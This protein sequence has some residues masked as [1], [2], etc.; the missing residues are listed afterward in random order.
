MK[1]NLWKNILRPRS[2][3]KKKNA[4]I[5]LRLQ[6]LTRLSLST[7][8]AALCPNYCKRVVG[9]CPTTH[10]YSLCWHIW[11]PPTMP[12][13]RGQAEHGTHMVVAVLYI[14]PNYTRLFSHSIAP[15]EVTYIVTLI[16]HP[17]S[18]SK[19]TYMER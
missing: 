18:R 13:A 14:W 11:V 2:V 17:S 3:F 12:I 7:V 5:N 19:T 15:V 8:A 1:Y 6:V 16:H 4:F 10:Q 9:A